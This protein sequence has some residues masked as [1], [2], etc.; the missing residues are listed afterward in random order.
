MK[1]ER[2]I[3]GKSLV[4]SLS[5]FVFTKHVERKK[6]RRA[7]KKRGGTSANR[8]ARNSRIRRLA[9]SRSVADCKKAGGT[10]VRIS[11]EPRKMH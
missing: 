4:F 6:I 3:D 7:R 11:N 8:C 5:L 10:S 2:R 9:N 1:T